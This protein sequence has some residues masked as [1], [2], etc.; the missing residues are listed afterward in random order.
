ML[1]KLSG[2]K[3]TYSHRRRSRNVL[4][5]V[6]MEILRGEMIAV[7]GA[8]GS[9]KSTLLNILGGLDFP[10]SGSYCYN[11]KEIMTGKQADLRLFRREH[12]GIVPQS[13]LLINQ[14]SAYKN[15]ALPLE[16]RKEKHIR[17]KIES[18]SKMLRIEELIGK[19]PGKLSVGECQRVA[20]ARAVIAQPEL[21]LA[22][23]PTSALDQDSRDI[24]AELFS[25]LCSTGTTIIIVTHDHGL[26]EKCGRS[27]S[28]KCGILH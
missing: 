27:L 24:V 16:I 12:I 9:G 14:I 6:S 10:D 17:E 26:A 19:K 25:R 5:D 3:K 15:I 7:M 18:V 13:L 23:E 11:G 21:I 28:L 20:I 4:T 2:I 22:D 1:I 8:S